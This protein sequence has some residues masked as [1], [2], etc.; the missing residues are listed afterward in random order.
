MNIKWNT[1]NWERVFVFQGRVS[2]LLALEFTRTVHQR[3]QHN[4]PSSPAFSNFNGL[5]TIL[6]VW[7]HGLPYHRFVPVQDLIFSFISMFPLIH[8]VPLSISHI[9]NLSL[10][11]TLS[12]FFLVISLILPNRNPSEAQ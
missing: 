11:L 10:S 1:K 8:T 3:A 5:I 12:L 9:F 7:I 2:L 4:L 6:P